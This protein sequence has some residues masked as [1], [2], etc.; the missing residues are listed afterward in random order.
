MAKHLYPETCPKDIN[1][2]VATLQ[3][4]QAEISKKVGKF[5]LIQGDSV[6]DYFRSYGDALH[7]GYDRFGLGSFLVRP[8]KQRDTA[9]RMARVGRVRMGSR[10][11]TARPRR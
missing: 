2:E 1:R 5:V 9:I 10:L 7:E 8:V 11:R 4:H 3:R 6:V